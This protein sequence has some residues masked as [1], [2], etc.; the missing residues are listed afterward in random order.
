MQ[1]AG[2]REGSVATHLQGE[3]GGGGRS[4]ASELQTIQLHPIFATLA[5]PQEIGRFNLPI[6]TLMP[7]TLCLIHGPRGLCLPKCFLTFTCNSHSTFPTQQRRNRTPL[8]SSLPRN[9]R[10]L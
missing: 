5:L 8:S 3:I 4:V 9:K 6:V 2:T 7:V 10:P 1:K